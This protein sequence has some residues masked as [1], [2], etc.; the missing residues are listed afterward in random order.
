MF[1]AHGGAAQLQPEGWKA[2]AAEAHVTEAD[3]R[4]I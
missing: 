2:F 1:G 3:R 4:Y